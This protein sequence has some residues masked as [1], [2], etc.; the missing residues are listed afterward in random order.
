MT[1]DG[2]QHLPG[3]WKFLVPAF[4]LSY[5]ALV[6]WRDKALW[7]GGDRRLETCFS[8]VNDQPAMAHTNRR[9]ARGPADR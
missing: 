3:R 2:L 8:S 1:A 4:V 9:G 5:V 7:R 6:F